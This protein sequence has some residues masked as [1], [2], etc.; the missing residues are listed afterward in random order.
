MYSKTF[1]SIVKVCR[2]KMAARVTWPCI[3][4]EHKNYLSILQNFSGIYTK[5]G[6]VYNIQNVK[7]YYYLICYWSSNQKTNHKI[8][9]IV[10]ITFNLIELFSKTKHVFKN[11]SIKF[12]KGSL[13]TG[14][15]KY[16]LIWQTSSPSQATFKV[17]SLMVHLQVVLHWKS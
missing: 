2:V 6:L 10:L 11:K 1:W 15:T 5:N 3:T 17:Y 7:T 13:N 16:F 4:K 9:I 14:T 8:L 12:G